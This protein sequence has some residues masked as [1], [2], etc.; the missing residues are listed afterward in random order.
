MTGQGKAEA[1]KTQSAGI[2]AYWVLVAMKGC[3]VPYEGTPADELKCV[4]ELENA[5]NADL[6]TMDLAPDAR[7]TFQR[8]H[9]VF[10]VPRG[11]TKKQ[12]RERS[13]FQDLVSCACHVRTSPYV[14]EHANGQVY[15]DESG[16]ELCFVEPRR[17]LRDLPKWF[18]DYLQLTA[19]VAQ[20]RDDTYPR[21]ESEL[22]TRAARLTEDLDAT[23]SMAS[24]PGRDRVR[25]EWLRT[26]LK[27]LSQS[28]EAA[29]GEKAQETAAYLADRVV[30]AFTQDSAVLKPFVARLIKDLPLKELISFAGE[31][32]S[33][34]AAKPKALPQGLTA[35]N[36]P[37]AR[38]R[39]LQKWT[40]LARAH[41]SKEES[42]VRTKLDA[43]IVR[44]QQALAKH[45]EEAIEERA[46]TEG[47]RTEI[48]RRYGGSSSNVIALTLPTNNPE[49]KSIIRL[50]NALER[51]ATISFNGDRLQMRDMTDVKQLRDLLLRRIGTLQPAEIARRIGLPHS[52][53]AG[54]LANMRKLANP[55]FH[56]LV[57]VAFVTRCDV[58]I[59]LE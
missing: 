51:R 59:L 31:F 55:K 6:E 50:A 16:I 10:G 38:I 39:E 18:Q 40:D 29:S 7:S 26:D 12:P 32:I 2:S 27:S 20:E 46:R 4:C 53:G 42:A 47:G 37:T 35:A 58:T 56:T 48:N 21:F 22:Y 9:R 44:K 17:S 36:L 45:I 1:K 13:E 3:F 52:H 28:V 49:L 33:Q 34:L 57:T 24:L 15:R 19:S 54:F 41:E 5:V 30:F 8:R 43:L 11:W 25:M 14:T 23:L